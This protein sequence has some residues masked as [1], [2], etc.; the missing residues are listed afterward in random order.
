MFVAFHEIIQ[1][2]TKNSA[3]SQLITVAGPKSQVA[4]LFSELSTHEH[5]IFPPLKTKLQIRES[6]NWSD[7]P[8]L[9][10]LDIIKLEY[11]RPLDFLVFA[12]AR[13]F[14]RIRYMNSFAGVSLSN[15]IL[16]ICLILDKQFHSFGTSTMFL[17]LAAFTTTAYPSRTGSQPHKCFIIC[18]IFAPSR[19][20]E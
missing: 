7:G 9:F 8:T 17:I 16:Y 4:I 1:M 12:L 15:C 14:G 18:L 6:P 3:F 5:T 10:D 19:C 2:Y 11:K 13:V 20:A